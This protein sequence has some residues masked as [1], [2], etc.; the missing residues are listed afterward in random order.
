MNLIDLAYIKY[1][2][3][4]FIGCLFV[5]Y[6]LRYIS[7]VKDS[8]ISVNDYES[9][10]KELTD[11]KKRANE[12]AKIKFADENIF[13]FI[14]CINIPQSPTCASVGNGSRETVCR[15]R[16]IDCNKLKL[17]LENDPVAIER[18]KVATDR[19][20]QTGKPTNLSDLTYPVTNNWWFF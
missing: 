2:I 6:I 16:Q 3:I 15:S 4:F 13:N 20:Y 10:K 17:V 5:I 19:F 18:M 12:L 1:L 8:C 9:L 14:R 11:V 7:L